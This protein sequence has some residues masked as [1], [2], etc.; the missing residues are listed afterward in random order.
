MAPSLLLLL[1]LL[2]V[3]NALPQCSQ[4]VTCGEHVVQYPFLLNSP[5]SDC[6][7]P[8]LDLVCESNTELILPINSH[9]YRVLSIDY[10][11]HTVVVSDAEVDGHAGCPRFHANLTIDATSSWLELTGSDSF[12]TFVYNC[13]EKENVSISLSSFAAE[14]SGCQGYYGNRSY[15]LVD[16]MELDSYE[17]GLDCEEAVVV[18][19]LD[20]RKQAVEDAIGTPQRSVNGSIVDDV[21]RAG[22]E[23]IYNANSYECGRC[24]SSG[25]WCSSWRHN[26]MHGGMSFTCFCDNGPIEDDRCGRDARRTRMYIIESTSCF[27]SLCLLILALFLNFKYGFLPCKPKVKPRIESFLQKNGNQHTKRYTYADVK[28]MTKSFAVKLGQG[29]FG[30]VYK[31]S[32]SNG[33][34]VA[35]KMLKDT[36]GDGEEFMNEVAS[37]SRTSH[38]NVVTLFGF[39]LEGS[40]RALIY[41]YMPNGSL[42]RYGFSNNKDNENTLSWDKLFDIA[43]GIARGLEYLHRGC[44]TRIVHF[45]IKPHNILLDQDFCPKISDFGLAKLCLNKESAISICGARGT[46]GY[47]APEVFSKQFGTV[48]SKSDV[49]SYGMMVLEMVGAR[50]KNINVDSEASSQ[51]FPQWIYEHLDEY[52]ISA[53]EINNET[54]ELVR[55]MIVVGLWCIQ[56]I[57]TD[58]PT[59][60]RVVEMLEGTT[61]NLELPPKVLLS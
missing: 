55:K 6:S 29:G 59:M 27:L 17:Y 53:S 37:I 35:V 28:R 23:L 18:P 4:V 56:V 40:K 15:A 16:N 50:D 12:I 1:L 20:T 38:V 61:C 44:N 34:Q 3:A 58:R 52:C 25:G 8:G 2:A 26:N 31:G 19:V 60:T 41:E 33:C 39:C 10:Q 46:I 43:V 54:T 21:V 51:Y 13:R 48:S 14:L 47:I 22:F 9:R 49:Y 57:S 32:L 30:A 7:Y 24:E 5:E 42:E 11:T 36:K 45:D